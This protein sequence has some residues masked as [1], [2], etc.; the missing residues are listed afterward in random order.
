MS[1]YMMNK[2]LRDVEMHDQAV[3]EYAADPTAFIDRWLF[4]A[5]SAAEATDDRE[6][7]DTERRAFA[8]RDYATLYGLGINPYL[9][10]HFV[11]AVD[12]RATP[13]MELKEQYRAAISPCGEKESAM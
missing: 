9:L 3:V 13:W 6:L 8:D 10:W 1:R 2:F 7:T 4:G 12:Q 11:E 5:G